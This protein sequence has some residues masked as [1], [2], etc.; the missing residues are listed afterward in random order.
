V[1]LVDEDLVD[2]IHQSIHILGAEFISKGREALHVT[3]H[4]RDLS[5]L[6]FY[7]VPL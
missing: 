6:P 2:L 3:E 1:D 7:L 5:L 4:H